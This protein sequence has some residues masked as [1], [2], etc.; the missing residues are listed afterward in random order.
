MLLRGVY[1]E[2]N[3]FVDEPPD[4]Y[5]QRISLD[6]CPSRFYSED[7]SSA[8]GFYILGGL[9]AFRREFPHMAAIGW[10]NENTG[11][12]DYTC[13]GS[14]IS[15]R[16]VVTAGH[17]GLNDDRIPPNVVRLG[18]TNL[19]S[20]EDD[21]FA[22]DIKIKQFIPHPSY[23]RSQKYF[24]IALIELEQD[25]KLDSSVCPICLWPKDN[26]QTFTGGFQVAGFGITDYASDASPTL[27]KASLNYW[28]YDACNT[29][30]PR[31]RSLYRGLT[32]DQ[33]CSKTPSKDTC[34]G[35]SGGPIQ[36]DL[37]DVN[38]VIPYLVGVTSF[39][40]GCWDGSFGVY[41]KISSY[42]RWIASIANVTVDP[43]ECARQSECLSSRKFSDSRI[44]PQNNSPFFRVELQ[45]SGE[46][47]N[48]CSGALIDYRHV[49][50]SAS[51]TRWNGRDPSHIKANEQL[52]KIT[53][54]IRHPSYVQGQ[55]YD[56]I[57]VLT[58]EKFY[59]SYKIY[60]IVAPACIW[61]NERIPEPIVFFSGYGP[62]F[63]GSAADKTSAVPLKILTAFYLEN[64][65]CNANYSSQFQ[66][67]LPGG[68]NSN[69]ICS[70]N[71][72]D[73]VPEICKLEPGGPISNFR[74]DNIVPYVYGINTL[75]E[76]CGGAGNVFVATRIS[77]YY[78]WIESIVL[79]RTD[80]AKETPSKIADGSERVYEPLIVSRNDVA[81]EQDLADRRL[82]PYGNR[83]VPGGLKRVATAAVHHR[84]KEFTENPLEV[85]IYGT[86]LKHVPLNTED[87]LQTLDSIAVQHHRQDQPPTPPAPPPLTNS[88][89]EILKSL[90]LTSPQPNLEQIFHQ[91]TRQPSVQFSQY[92]ST[93]WRPFL[94]P[95]TAQP[96]ISPAAPTLVQQSSKPS[97]GSPPCITTSSVTNTRQPAQ[98]PVP[99]NQYFPRVPAPSTGFPSNV[100]SLP[101]PS[102][103]I[104]KSVELYRDGRCTS[105]AGLAGRCLH[106]SFCR[107]GP[108]GTWLG[109]GGGGG[110]IIR[111][112]HGWS[113]CNYDLLIVC[114]P[115]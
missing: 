28:D 73:L 89:F 79:N 11:T 87:L 18:D 74:R 71:P 97:I 14:L 99:V 84:V 105:S 104:T 15:S 66:N 92:G 5:Y 38:K 29:N 9:R 20:R 67:E 102:F 13:G 6:D 107:R 69:F 44:T 57:A 55:N 96:F 58:L 19:A 59:N 47:F 114:C 36:I 64:G 46:S 76:Q 52:I 30:L 51:C 1:G 42:I 110:G 27:Q 32:P 45:R 85:T 33:F 70:E 98:Q 17:C 35:D 90:E 49:V 88:S 31:P 91:Q 94:S 4:G 37:N 65:R 40:T 113:Y 53:E 7:V 78:K 26:L 21:R 75:G 61:N 41:T 23:K 60:Q 50:T 12:V 25:A 108:V 80:P 81:F 111:P 22:Q 103:S 83:L 63:T 2:D 62:D 77:F 106:Y 3:A 101:L 24:D 56:D 86:Q 16:F 8:L 10:V 112:D 54:I 95:S 100:H 39:G 72:I 115:I 82:R 109:S 48:H 68:F 34:H 43:L 93:A